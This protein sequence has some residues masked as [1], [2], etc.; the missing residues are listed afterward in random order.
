MVKIIGSI[1][2]AY[3]IGDF[4]PAYLCARLFGKLDIRQHGSGNAGTTNVIRVMG[5]RYGAGVF[6]LDIFKG[7]LAVWLGNLWGGQ[8]G[9][10]ASGFGVVLGHDFPLLLGFKGG[11]GIAATLGIFLF[12]FPLATLGGAVF[13]VLIVLVTKM[14]SVGSLSFVVLMLGYTVFTQQSLAVILLALG[15]V[16]LAFLQHRGNIQRILQGEENKLSLGKK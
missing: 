15:L 12:V 10:V 3:F 6:V 9:I 2:P 5:W 4:S 1:I 14:V 16:L 8:I 11:K 13:F 7:L